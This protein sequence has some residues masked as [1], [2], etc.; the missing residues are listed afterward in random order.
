MFGFKSKTDR[1]YE[2]LQPLVAVQTVQKGLP[3]GFW[4]HPFVLGYFSFFARYLIEDMF[5]SVSPE[6]AGDV[7]SSTMQRLSNLNGLAI[8][9]DIIRYSAPGSI[10]PDFDH[11]ADMAAVL[12]FYM[13]GKAT[14]STL[15]Y[16]NAAI[17]SLTVNGR[18]P[19]KGMVSS[20]I[21]RVTFQKEVDRLFGV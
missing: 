4:Q 6:V 21:F 18:R 3:K 2:I 1:V 10:H 12:A 20:E 9:E 5:G 17:A 8:S 7:V 19:D 13:L 14:D 15:P 11:G 16:V